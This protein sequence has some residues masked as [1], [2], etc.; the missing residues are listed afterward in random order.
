MA[1][2]ACT[3]LTLRILRLTGIRKFILNIAAKM[4]PRRELLPA[5]SGLRFILAAHVLFFHF[6][7]LF[8][9]GSI[10]ARN[11]RIKTSTVLL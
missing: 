11:W 6:A 8:L 10:F 3:S 7:P 2:N 1:S 9:G 5:L 4:R